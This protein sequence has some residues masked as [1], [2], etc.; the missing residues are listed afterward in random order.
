MLLETASAASESDV[1]RLRRWS[2]LSASGHASRC[3]AIFCRAGFV[4]RRSQN[5]LPADRLRSPRARIPSSGSAAGATP[6]SAPVIV[7]GSSPDQRGEPGAPSRGRTRTVKPTP[8]PSARPRITGDPPL[9]APG[10]WPAPT[11]SGALDRPSRVKA[12]RRRV[13]RKV[14]LRPYAV[15]VNRRPL[16]LNEVEV[17]HGR[18]PGITVSAR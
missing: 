7:A 13:A 11:R 15:G 9:P 5:E 8:K 10:W 2:S 4:R 12:R 18:S 6:A 1:L 3:P 16:G 14:R 17:A